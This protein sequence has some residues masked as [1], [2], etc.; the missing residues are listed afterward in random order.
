MCVEETCPPLSK[1]NN[2]YPTFLPVL[3]KTASTVLDI[4]PFQ[5]RE[6]QT[7]EGD[8]QRGMYARGK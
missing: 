1:K 4:E 2:I 8:E 3:Y 7:V 5:K 6:L